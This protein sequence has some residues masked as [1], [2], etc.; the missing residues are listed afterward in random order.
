MDSSDNSLR[1]HFYR[2]QHNIG[3]DAAS[4]AR[5]GDQQLALVPDNVRFAVK[6]LSIGDR[7]RL[8]PRFAVVGRR[9]QLERRALSRIRAGVGFD[10]NHENAPVGGKARPALYH[11]LIGNHDL[12][13]APC[14][15]AIFA[16]HHH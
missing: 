11:L 15:A 4:G 7:K 2:R 8:A 10:L 3:I 6:P 1:F 16:A 9:N 5:K 14:F 13:L 12:R